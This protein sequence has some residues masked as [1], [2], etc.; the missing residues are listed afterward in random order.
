M[1]LSALQQPQRTRAQQPARAIRK[2][3]TS[4]ENI[5]S[6]EEKARLRPSRQPAHSKWHV[7][8]RCTVGVCSCS[9]VCSL[10][11]HCCTCSSRVLAPHG[12]EVRAVQRVVRFQRQA[13]PKVVCNNLN[14]A[15]DSSTRKVCAVGLV[16]EIHLVCAERRLAAGE[17]RRLERG[18]RSRERCS[19][20]L[21]YSMVRTRVT[22]SV[23][24]ER[25]HG[26]SHT[27]RSASSLARVVR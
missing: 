23:H 25:L 13:R 22:S 4:A 18:I 19:S 24:M 16:L 12:R 11:V 17:S 8:Y 9:V 1:L 21:M 6:K 14:K 10:E 7:P 3:N 26:S 27:S 15:A 20:L 5:G 2:S